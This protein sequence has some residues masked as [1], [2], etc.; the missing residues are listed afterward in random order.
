MNNNNSDWIESNFDE[1]LSSLEESKPKTTKTSTPTIPDQDEDELTNSFQFQFAKSMLQSTTSKV[2]P[3]WFSFGFLKP[4]FINL[5]E[6]QVF[7]R[8]INSV[9]PLNPM[10]NHIEEPDLFV[11][12]VA[13]FTL[14]IILDFQMK[15]SDV[16]VVGL[17]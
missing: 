3:S 13:T 1:N 10:I 8:I 6:K 9:K 2:V 15:F 17:F 5:E 4:Y 7:Q 11:P 16:H 14:A 12:L